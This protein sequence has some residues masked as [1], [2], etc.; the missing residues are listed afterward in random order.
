MKDIKKQQKD[1]RKAAKEEV[2]NKNRSGSG[3]RRG[4]PPWPGS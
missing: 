3:N 1:K 2:Q 4:G